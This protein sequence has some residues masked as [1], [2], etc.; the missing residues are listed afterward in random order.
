MVEIAVKQQQFT[1]GTSPI[2]CLCRTSLAIDAICTFA[3]DGNGEVTGEVL[4]KLFMN[5]LCKDIYCKDIYL[6]ECLNKINGEVF[7]LPI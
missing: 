4:T 5:D 3:G 1:S 2:Y 7:H 6:F